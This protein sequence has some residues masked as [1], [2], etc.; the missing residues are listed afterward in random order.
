MARDEARHAGFINDALR[1][2]GIAVNLGFLTQQKKYTYFRPKFI[3]YATY[4]SRKDRLC[5][6][7]HDL[8]AS[9]SSTQSTGSTRSS[10]GSANG[11]TT[12]SAMARP[13]PCC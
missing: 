12:S 7:H 9:R 11:A 13:S 2:A 1:E 8:P 5:P 3:Y 10:S 6:L 4:L